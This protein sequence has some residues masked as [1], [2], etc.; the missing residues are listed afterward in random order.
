M[1]NGDFVAGGSFSMAGGLP[2]NHVARWNGSSWTE[3]GAGTDGR[4]QALLPLPNGDL[5]VGGVFSNAGGVPASRIARWD[6][7]NW[8]T[9]GAGL[10]AGS[11]SGVE[12]LALL[13]NGDVIAGGR[14]SAV[15]VPNSA[16]IARWN[17]VAWSSMGNMESWVYALQVLPSGDLLAAGPFS[18]AGG[19]QANQVALWNGSAWSSLQGSVNDSS[20]YVNALA[21]LINGDIAVGGTFEMVNGAVSKC[22][23]RYRFAADAPAI[24][25]HPQSASPCL[26]GPVSLAVAATGT[27]PMLYQWR[28]NDMALDTIAHPSASTPTLSFD[29]VGLAEQ[30]SYDCVVANS[31]DSA[32]SLEAT[33]VICFADFNC[34]GFVEV[35]DIF[36]FLSAWFA[37][38]ARA[39]FDGSGLPVSVPDIFAFLSAWFAG[40]G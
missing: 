3:L 25:Q 22:F 16:N 17:G 33:V 34:S 11:G 40:C 7:L 29:S 12:T 23:A 20:R 21:L 19:V 32:T 30:G 9:L 36:A 38:D 2:A 1:P 37:N 4:V 14:F 39:D 8:T 31:C 26:G 24:T 28:R 5:I 10:S 13:P 18:A 15:G 35:P 27:Q 6:G